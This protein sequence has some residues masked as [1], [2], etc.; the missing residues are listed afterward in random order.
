MYNYDLFFNEQYEIKGK[1]FDAQIKEWSTKYKSLMTIEQKRFLMSVIVENKIKNVLEIGIFN[2]VSSLCILKAGLSNYKDFNLYGIDVNSDKN[3]VGQAVYGFCDEEEIKHYHINI[4][5]TSF[6]IEDIVPK[7]IK[8]DLIF[9]DA[10]HHHPFPIFDLILSIPYMHQDSIILLHDVI[11]YFKP[12]DWGGSFIFESWK[13]DKYRIFNNES[14]MPSSMG[15]IK[16]PKTKQELYNNIKTIANIPF[17]PIPWGNLEYYKS[18]DI[19]DDSLRFNM[20]TLKNLK[21]IMEKYYPE[22]FTNEIYNM[23]KNNYEEYKKILYFI[24]M[25]KDLLIYYTKT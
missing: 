11:N 21:T 13:G 3:F 8:F 19:V 18:V 14:E 23:L 6:N 4:G 24:Y 7:D 9:I 16:L 5:K 10:A 2:G 12:H 1:Q 15:C 22:D 20:D 25:S 17:K